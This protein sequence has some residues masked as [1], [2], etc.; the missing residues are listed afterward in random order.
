[1]ADEK[2]YH[3]EEILDQ[4]FPQEGDEATYGTSGGST[5]SDTKTPAT[6]QNKVIPRRRIAQELIGSAL[7]TKSRKI[8]LEF[9][10]TPSGALQIGK[11]E[12][13]VSGDIRI[14]PNG[15][16]ARDLAGLITFAL[17]ATTGDAVFKGSVQAGS[18]ITGAV[19]VG[20]NDI[21]I[22]G[23]SKTMIFYTDDTP[24]IVIGEV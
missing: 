23:E 14:S 21:V 24:S 13:G 7:N 12:N 3:A 2:V 15:I 10:F 16:T 20:D 6:I 11:Y 9:Q 4:P 22:D 1:M 8:L 19:A 17:D 18:V 5:A